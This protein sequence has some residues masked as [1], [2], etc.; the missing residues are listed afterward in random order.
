MSQTNKYIQEQSHPINP[1]I[2]LFDVWNGLVEESKA[3][4][5]TFMITIFLSIIYLFFTT[6]M[7]LA[8][9]YLL[10][11]TQ[12]DVLPMNELSILLNSNSNNTPE[13]VFKAFK[14]NL[15]SRQSL[16]AVFDEYKLIYTYESDFDLLSPLEKRKAEQDS[17]DEFLKH[18][19]VQL[20]DK[21]NDLG[22]YVVSLSL[23]TDE[24]VVVNILNDLVARAIDKTK[25][26]IY[27][28]LIVE[29]TTRERQLQQAIDSA[30]KVEKDRRRDRIAQLSE[31]LLIT[32]KLGI[33]KPL[34][35]GPRLISQSNSFPLYFLGSELLEVE[36]AVLQSRENDDPFVS[37]LRD[38]Q[39]S[40]NK[41][42]SLVIKQ[43]EFGVAK[44][45]MMA[46]YAEKIKPKK[47]LILAAAGILGL[48]LGVFIAL[49]R[50][51]AKNR[52]TRMMG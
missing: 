9:S 1:Q 5:I 8:T 44:I 27:E 11:P 23:E 7:Y 6:P 47:A 13:S 37:E 52:K 51:A 49:I 20:N 24:K 38:W 32:Q 26:Q 34:A 10:P 41:L 21:K 18:F 30:R 29:K 43:S 45:D 50:R 15:E 4:L 42:T 12:K 19:S 39:Q 33:K 31:A 46:D 25:V 14:M 28:Q 16:K 35:S 3:I 22:G 36:R 2:D 17:F 40:L 48:M